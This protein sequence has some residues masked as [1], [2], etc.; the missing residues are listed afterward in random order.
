M[1]DYNQTTITNGTIH[2]RA[3]H[4]NIENPLGGI[5]SVQFNEENV[6]DNNGVT[7]KFPSSS[8]PLQLSMTDPSV[9]FNLIDPTDGTTVLGTATYQ[10]LYVSIY[11]LYLSLAAMRD[12]GT[13]V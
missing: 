8:Q 9:T 5:P 6:L 7:T 2:T 13:I 10:Q 12:A 11:S 3:Y 4:V 1:A